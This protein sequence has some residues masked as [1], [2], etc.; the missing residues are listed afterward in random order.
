MAKVTQGNSSQPCDGFVNIMTWK[1]QSSNIA[2]VIGARGGL[3]FCRPQKSWDAWFP[4]SPL[5]PQ[6]PFCR[7]DFYLPLQIAARGGPR[8]LRLPRCATVSK[9][10]FSV[11]QISRLYVRVKHLM[12]VHARLCTA[13]IAVNKIP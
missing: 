13:D 5:S 10:T 6:P 11:S 7:Y 8:P 9:A 1:F 2:W 12:Q 4:D 3:Q